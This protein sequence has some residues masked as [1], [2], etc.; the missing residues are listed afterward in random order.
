MSTMPSNALVIA[1]NPPR[2]TRQ[3][4]PAFEHH[5]KVGVHVPVRAGRATPGLSAIALATPGTGTCPA[6]LIVP[7]HN[8][9]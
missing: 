4:T 6:T 2:V 3:S 5:P 8:P 1:R 7:L 9:R